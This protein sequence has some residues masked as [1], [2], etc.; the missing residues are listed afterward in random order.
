MGCV[1][2]QLWHLLSGITLASER[3]KRERSII[4]VPVHHWCSRLPLLPGVLVRQPSGGPFK[5]REDRFYDRH[6]ISGIAPSHSLSKNTDR[7]AGPVDALLL[8]KA[9]YQGISW[10]HG[11]KWNIRENE[12]SLLITKLCQRI[13]RVEWP[14][15]SISMNKNT[16]KNFISLPIS[17]IQ[18][19]PFFYPLRLFCISFSL[20]KK[21]R[22]KKRTRLLIFFILHLFAQE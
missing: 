12:T 6:F 20:M 1:R 13:T 4:Y 21:D 9:L 19:Q 18:H 22:N 10:K 11:M 16:F 8:D 14:L 7:I 17:S 3:K 2:C 5:L 15:G